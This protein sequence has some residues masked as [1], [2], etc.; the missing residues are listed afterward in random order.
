MNDVSLIWACIGPTMQ[1]VRGRNFVVK[2]EIY[3]TLTPGQRAL[4]MF[5]VL[6]GHTLYGVEEFYSHFSYL[7]SNKSF[8]SQLKKGMQYFEDY[9]MLQILEQMDIV[10]QSLEIEKSK[11]SV[12]QYNIL[13]ADIDKNTE[14]STSIS[15]LNKSL[16]DTLPLTV[17]LVATY[18]R[19]N[20]DEFVK[21]ID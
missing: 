1:Q 2:S 18:I 16:N 17:K 14:L 5:Q 10:F 13:I 11:E 12:E 3:A 6:Y 15:L 20:A 19:D 8:W 21:L 7:L 4:F 9:A